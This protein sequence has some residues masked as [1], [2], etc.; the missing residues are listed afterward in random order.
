MKKS[1][2][3][4]HMLKMVSATLAL[5]NASLGENCVGRSLDLTAVE[6]TGILERSAGRRI[7]RT[8]KHWQRS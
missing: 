1:S 4:S 5:F 7:A 2:A 8:L 3:T 6:A